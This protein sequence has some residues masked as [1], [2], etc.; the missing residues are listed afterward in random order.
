M[1]KRRNATSGTNLLFAFSLHFS[2]SSFRF[3]NFF[4]RHFLVLPPLCPCI[5]LWVV[6]VTFG[7]SVSGTFFLST[8]PVTACASCQRMQPARKEEKIMYLTN[9]SMVELTVSVHQADER[10]SSVRCFII[11][12]YHAACYY[13]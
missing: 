4:A 9:I 1:N 6:V 3:S 7:C 5:F 12:Q 10:V 8:V 2:S 13:W 11:H